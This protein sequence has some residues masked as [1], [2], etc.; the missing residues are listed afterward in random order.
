MSNNDY[1]DKLNNGKAKEQYET[2]LDL[3]AKGDHQSLSRASLLFIRA[4]ESGYNP[5]KK[6][7]FFDFN[8]KNHMHVTPN[9]FKV[10]ENAA[11]MGYVEAQYS[12]GARY[13]K[14]LDVPK[15][16]DKAFLWFSKAAENGHL[17]ANYYLGKMY[18]KGRGTEPD[19]ITGLSYIVRSANLG[20]P[21]AQHDMG[22]FR[23]SG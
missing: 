10:I 23:E 20:Y 2:G 17:G 13:R 19:P 18:V 8:R 7:F 9:R 21:E 14:G 22:K 5:A 1:L 6:V 11:K 3:E 15:D 12:L 4:A 16:Y